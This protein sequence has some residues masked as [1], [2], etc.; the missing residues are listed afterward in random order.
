MHNKVISGTLPAL[1]A[2]I[3]E[4]PAVPEKTSEQEK[5]LG[6]SLFMIKQHLNKALDFERL[7]AKSGMSYSGYRKFFKRH[8][9]LALNQYLIR[10]KLLLAQR[11]I[12]NTSLPLS[13]VAAKTGFESI[14][15]FSRLYKLK[16]GYSPSREKR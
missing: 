9:G 12:R 7:A 11:L 6:D 16:F 5:L 10:E 3:L 2:M 15:Y 1:I 4:S 13:E 14:H 8:T